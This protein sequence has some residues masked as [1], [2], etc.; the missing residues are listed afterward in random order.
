MFRE[1]LKKLFSRIRPQKKE[2]AVPHYA[3]PSA[4]NAKTLAKDAIDTVT[5]ISSIGPRLSLSKEERMA[6]MRVMAKMEEFGVDAESMEFSAENRTQLLWE[7]I[8]GYALPAVPLLI[9][10]GQPFFAFL[11]SLVLLSVFWFDGI[12]EKGIFSRF[13]KKETGM[14]VSGKISPESPEERI[15]FSS[16]LDSA[17]LFTEKDPTKLFYAAGGSLALGTVLSCIMT[18][19]ELVKGQLFSFN[20]NPWIGIFLAVPLLALSVFSMKIA[21]LYSGKVSPGAG[22]NLSGV[23]VALSLAKYFSKNRLKHTSV[24]FAFF[25]SEETGKAGSREWFMKHEKD[26]SLVV[27]VD[28]LYSQDDL[29]VLM[30]DGNGTVK[31]DEALALEI[32]GLAIKMGYRMK[33][34]KL[35]FLSGSTDALNAAKAGFPA[36]TVTSMIPGSENPGHTENDTPET[37][38]QSVLETV[39]AVLIRFAEDRDRSHEIEETKKEESGFLSSDRK[40]MITRD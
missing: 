10:L 11:S 13:M 12:M 9:L 7:K 5:E 35:S 29:A 33:T 4:M 24:E 14:N 39:I 1:G 19:F 15:I 27:N 28:G 40:Y 37:I 38:D 34:G 3:F 32:E 22:D 25:S 31:L 18:I 30:S 16:H 36:T 21:K 2:E 23:G 6:A 26:G 20:F 8:T 17:R